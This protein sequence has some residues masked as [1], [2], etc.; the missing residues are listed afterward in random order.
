MQTGKSHGMYL[1]EQSLNDL[2]ASKTITREVALELAE[3]KK[4]ITA[5]A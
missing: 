4:L 3:E 2:V 5:G 1:L